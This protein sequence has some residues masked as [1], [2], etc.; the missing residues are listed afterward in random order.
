VA[1]EPKPA[2]GWTPEGW[3]ASAN[4][5]GAVYGQILVTSIVAALSEEE[6]LGAHEIFIGVLGTMLVFWLAHVY[7][8][9]VA[10]RLSRPEVLTVGE[11]LAIARDEWP[12]VQSAAPALL[13]LGLAWAGVLSTR[14]G[15]DLAIAAG[16]G[17]LFA[18]GL[19]IARRSGLSPAGTVGSMALSGA[20]GL[21]IV[22]LKIVV[23]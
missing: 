3:L 2:R 1:A 11:T 13:A 18:W 22:G 15:I 19:V 4:V 12:M 21:V 8:A 10:R 6:T 20:F 9:A 14:A 23:H 5:A 16:I 17:A 7:A